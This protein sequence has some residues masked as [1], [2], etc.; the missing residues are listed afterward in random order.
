MIMFHLVRKLILLV[1]IIGAIL[2]FY[3]NI[4]NSSDLQ[5]ALD[6]AQS[7]IPTVDKICAQ[8]VTIAIH[9]QTGA[10]YTFPN[11]CLPEGW[12]VKTN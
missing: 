2:F 10:T 3:F 11:S 9:N 6:Q 4:K 5:K 8:K 7:F 12:K 1:V